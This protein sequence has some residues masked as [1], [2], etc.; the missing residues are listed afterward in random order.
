MWI[1]EVKA[2]VVVRMLIFLLYAD[3]LD[4]STPIRCDGK[5]LGSEVRTNQNR[6]SDTCRL[7]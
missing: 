6:S 7:D 3:E 5:V 2:K 4:Q 1:D